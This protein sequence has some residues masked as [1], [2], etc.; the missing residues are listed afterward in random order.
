[1]INNPGRLSKL[2]LSDKHRLMCDIQCCKLISFTA[3]LQ[4]SAAGKQHAH[5]ELGARLAWTATATVALAGLTHRKLAGATG[6]G[7]AAVLV[8]VIAAK[9]VAWLIMSSCAI[10]IF[11]TGLVT[12]RSCD[13][14]VAH[15][16]HLT[17]PVM[18]AA[19]QCRPAPVL[20]AT[21]ASAWKG[22][23]QQQQ[24]RQQ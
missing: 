3:S 5:V 11:V 17:V 22:Q 10:A 18:T 2:C 20:H 12:A 21:G 13:K 24:L 19:A 23:Q 4:E 8:A 6:A 1:M 16:T 15:I 7:A 14:S 9:R